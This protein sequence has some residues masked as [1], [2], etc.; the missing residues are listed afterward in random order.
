MCDLDKHALKDYL[1]LIKDNEIKIVL[2]GKAG[3]GKGATGNTIFG[4]QLFQSGMGLS[5]ITKECSQK[6]AVRFDQNI[7]IVDTPGTFIRMQYED[8]RRVILTNSPDL[9][10]FIWVVQSD[11]RYTA[12][13]HTLFNN[14]IDVLG[15]NALKH[16]IILFTRKDE[17]DSKNQSLEYFLKRVSPNLQELVEKCGGRVIAFNNNL[18]GKKGDEQVKDLLSMIINNEE[19]NG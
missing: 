1:F 17:L 12:E 18:N 10:A 8:I 19:Q 6:S 14:F 11:S 13:E 15:R 5:D 16:C 3:S 9:L 4:K 2:V 7:L